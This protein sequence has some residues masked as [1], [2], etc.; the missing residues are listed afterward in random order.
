MI[1]VMPKRERRLGKVGRRGARQPMRRENEDRGLRKGRE[2]G[3][4]RMTSS[5]TATQPISNNG[6]HRRAQGQGPGQGYDSVQNAQRIVLL[7]LTDSVFG[8][9]ASAAHHQTDNCIIGGLGSHIIDPLLLL[10]ATYSTG[11]LQSQV[12]LFSNPS[13]PLWGHR[14][15][16]KIASSVDLII[17]Y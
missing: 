16:Q 14:D 15:Q 4:G 2:R 8:I 7:S 6:S 3:R 5:S 9:A 13:I 10:L 11:I 17:Y 12:A 1:D